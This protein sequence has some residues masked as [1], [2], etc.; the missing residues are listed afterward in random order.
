MDI[1]IMDVSVNL[2]KIE[3][4]NIKE[5]IMKVGDT[6]SRKD[7]ILDEIVSLQKT[8]EDDQNNWREQTTKYKKL[9]DD[10]DVIQKAYDELKAKLSEITTEWGRLQYTIKDIENTG[11]SNKNRLEELKRE[12]SRLLDIDKI[13]KA[14]LAE[15]KAF[16]EMCLDAKWRAENR[17]DGLGAMAHQI[18]GAINLAVAKRAILGDKRGLGK[19][20][21]SLIYCDLIEAKKVVAICPSDTMTN[22]AREILL[23]TPHRSP[24]IIGKTPRAE[25][26]FLFSALKS[27]SQF[28]LIVNYEAWRRDSRLIE[29]IQNLYPDTVLIDESHNIM[30]A[31]TSAA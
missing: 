18:E 15:R 13:N 14:I 6:M 26:D 9:T 19:S 23:W 5:I 31:G 1:R 8:I 25:R 22:F 28:T 4:I 21:T 16:S 30:N 10:R 17:D 29:D 11:K 12:L 7:E 27:A 20:L 24:I 2:V 3:L